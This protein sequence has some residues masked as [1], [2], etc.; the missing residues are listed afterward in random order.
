MEDMSEKQ[1]TKLISN[2][3]KWTVGVIIVLILFFGTI[4]TVGAGEVGV[5]TRFGAVNRVVNPG[6]GIKIP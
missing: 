4:F 2:I 1:K 3:I 6:L 5:V